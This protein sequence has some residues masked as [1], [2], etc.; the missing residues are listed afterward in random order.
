MV[1]P[2]S[3]SKAYRWCKVLCQSLSHNSHYL[4]K[5]REGRKDF[6]KK[7]RK[8]ENKG[9]L[10]GNSVRAGKNE[11][12]TERKVFSFTLTTI[13]KSLDVSNCNQTGVYWDINF[14]PG[15]LPFWRAFS[16]K[17]A[18]N[19]VWTM[20]PS[21][22]KRKQAQGLLSSTGSLFSFFHLFVRC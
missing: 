22:L 14:L 8:K 12:N 13:M 11:E 2:N 7:K 20:A 10:K 18:L 19:K 16:L 15:A 1:S 21:L 3:S 5:G 17:L 9:E 6:K 4:K